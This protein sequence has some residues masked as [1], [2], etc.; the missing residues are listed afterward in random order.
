VWLPGLSLRL[1]FPRDV[2]R[3]QFVDAVDGVVCDAAENLTQVAFRV[4]AVELDGL[5]RAPNYAEWACLLR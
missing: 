4:Q 2:P 5:R 1:A 3:Q